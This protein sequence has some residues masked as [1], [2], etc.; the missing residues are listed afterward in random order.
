MSSSLKTGSRD[1]ELRD[2]QDTRH[3]LDQGSATRG[4]GAGG[5]FTPVLHSKSEDR[6]DRV[7]LTLNVFNFFLR[8]DVRELFDPR[9]HGDI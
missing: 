5:S 8:H 6:G 3:E 1:G 4:S 7:T 9:N 2:A